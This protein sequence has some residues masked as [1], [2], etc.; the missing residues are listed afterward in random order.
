MHQ[1]LEKKRDNNEAVH[2]LL[3]DFRKAYDSFMREVLYTILTE[4]DIPME[5]LRLIN[6]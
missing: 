3:I 2:Q 4:F 5:V 1:R 6:M